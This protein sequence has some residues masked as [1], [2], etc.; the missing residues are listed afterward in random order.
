MAPQTSSDAEKVAEFITDFQANSASLL[1]EATQAALRSQLRSAEE[2]S[3][4]QAGNRDEIEGA[5]A[6][7]K[8]AQDTAE[9]AAEAERAASAELGKH[10]EKLADV[11]AEL[12]SA[13]SEY[14]AAEKAGAQFARE[15]QKLRE[16]KAS[17]E[18]TVSTFEVLSGGTWTDED[19]KSLALTSLQSYLEDIRAEKVL[20]AA[21][22]GLGVQPEERGLFDK[23]TVDA[24]SEVLTERA[25][26]MEE[27]VAARAPAEKEAKT[28]L[29]GL[30]ALVDVCQEKV[31]QAQGEHAMASKEL[32]TA[33]AAAK[34]SQLKASKL[35]TVVEKLSARHKMHEE[36]AEAA[37]EAL[38]AL[39]RLFGAAAEA[40]AVAS[41]A[42][43]EPEPKKAKTESVTS[44]RPEIAVASP[45]RVRA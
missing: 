29:M 26:S 14:A 27:Q 2:E 10:A 5:R 43:A 8:E 44:P 17:H 45:A 40:Q 21:V 20:V 19:A 6:V 22:P 28:E 4:K 35:E 15:G 38:A 30:S 42:V 37:R 18:V 12:A 16:A 23:F 25:Q 9:A 11:Q 39:E 34:A 36:K 1:E 33:K 41:E 3:S 32:K 7:A 24:I 31:E 13:K